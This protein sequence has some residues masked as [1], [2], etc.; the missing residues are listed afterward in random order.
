MDKEQEL[1]NYMMLIEQYKEQMA[2]LETQNQ[3]VQAAIAEYNRAKITL[4][5]LNNADGGDEI[6]I[7]IGGSAFVDAKVKSTSKV[8]FDIGGG[9][10]TEKK[11]EDAIKNIDKR[12][13]ELQKTQEKLGDMLQNFQNETNDAY[14]KAQKLM[15]EQQK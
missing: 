13:E 5:Q 12:I 8:L 3:Y 6:L 10:V 15:Q 2:Q 9:L 1:R 4:E 7:P 14:A 11:S